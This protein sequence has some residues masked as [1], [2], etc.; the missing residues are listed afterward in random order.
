MAGTTSAKRKL[1]FLDVILPETV[2]PLEFSIHNQEESGKTD[3]QV[4]VDIASRLTDAI[5]LKYKN[6]TSI[7]NAFKKIYLKNNI[8][9][10]PKRLDVDNGSEFKGMTKKWLNE[11]GVFVRYGKAGRSRQQALAE[12][13]NQEIGEEIL[14][15][16]LVKEIETNKVSKLWIHM[17][18]DI[19]SR[20][21]KIHERVKFK[22]GQWAA[23]YV[24]V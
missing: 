14:F 16:Q 7:L 1:V 9:K 24:Q 20:L 19:L 11:N 3:L 8:L 13:R 12:R 6:T 21:N 5:P 4:V 15:N 23:N 17:I 18:P 22:L 10:I 2:Y